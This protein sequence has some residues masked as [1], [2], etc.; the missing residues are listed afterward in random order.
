MLKVQQSVPPM[1]GKVSI[2]VLNLHS[3][4]FAMFVLRAQNEFLTH[5]STELD[6]VMLCD[7][8]LLL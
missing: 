8:L 7:F 4:T 2:I 3:V 6:S 1:E 5:V